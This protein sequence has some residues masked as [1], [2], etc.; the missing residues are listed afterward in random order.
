MPQYDLSLEELR[1][2]E[3]PRDEP[4]DFDAF[5]ATTVAEARAHRPATAFEPVDFGLRTIESFDV[6]FSGY[7]G[8]PIRGWLLLPRNRSGRLPVI[9][10][11]IGYGGGR[12]VPFDWL[13][14]AS[15]G[16]ANFVMDTRGQGSSWLRG[17]TAD[18]EPEGSSPHYPG[19]L[20]RGI[21]DPRTYYYRRVFV[22]AV[23]AVEAVCEHPAVDPDR[24]IVAGA[25]QGGGI[26][27]AVAGLAQEAVRAALVDVPFLSHFRRAVAVTDTEPYVELTRY[28]SAHRLAEQQV[29]RTLS[30]A[31]VRNFAA[32]AT[33]PALFSVG[34][35][36]TIAPP[37]TVFAAFNAYAG[38]KEIEVWPYTGHD[39]PDSHQLMRQLEFLADR[40]LAP[41]PD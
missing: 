5:W 2:Y 17:D 22:D 27:L 13:A 24:L 19:F 7:G 12:G 35:M 29:F 6:T 26:S 11:Y 15:A 31:D 16:Y 40:G 18:A 8:Q 30:Y 4:A 20:T 34:L 41:E 25:S 36:D 3:P 14:W 38:P 1:A 39:A 32:R 33:A 21:L 37:S 10:R 23:L 28:L 9:V